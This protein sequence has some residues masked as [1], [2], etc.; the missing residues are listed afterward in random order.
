MNDE[1]NIKNVLKNILKIRFQQS[2]NIPLCR[3]IYKYYVEY[4]NA[5]LG[6]I[7]KRIFYIYMKYSKQRK[8]KVL[9]QWKIITVKTN[10]LMNRV[11]ELVHPQKRMW[12]CNSYIDKTS[13]HLSIETQ[14]TTESNII[15][16]K[17][18]DFS[19]IP[20][21]KHQ[22]NKY[23]I[24]TL[25]FLNR[26]YDK[27]Y[28]NNQINRHDE[29]QLKKDLQPN[30]ERRSKTRK[31][32]S[33]ISNKNS[34]YINTLYKTYVN[35]DNKIEQLRLKRDTE[36]SSIYPFT[37]HLSSKNIT[38]SMTDLTFP[39][40][41]RLQQYEKNRQ[42]HLDLLRNKYEL[43]RPHPRSLSKKNS[44]VII[45]ISSNYFEL[46]KRRISAIQT[47]M[48]IEHSL[49]FKPKLNDRRNRSVK[50]NVIIRNQHFI[51]ERENKLFMTSQRGEKECTFTPSLI[52]KRAKI[53]KSFNER[54]VEYNHLYESHIE[55]IRLRAETNYSFTPVL[56]SNTD[57][58][59]KNKRI[60]NE[61]LKRKDNQLKITVSNQTKPHL[62]VIEEVNTNHIKRKSPIEN[63]DDII[64][65]TITN[66][67]TETNE[68]EDVKITESVNPIYVNKTI[69]K[70]SKSSILLKNI[71]N[72]DSKPKNQKKKFIVKKTQKKKVMV[73]S[74]QYYNTLA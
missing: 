23:K 32:S 53:H 36:L 34:D 74:F 50:D 15:I 17:Q 2:D 52:S 65:E 35:R 64:K 56:S 8:R 9:Y 5:N 29:R 22:K 72:K 68:K 30:S 40:L 60:L 39:F 44:Q 55:A 25:N 26:N 58:I 62:N 45:P 27:K 66:E 43:E 49:T 4:D 7:I 14:P 31:N 1:T 48:D 16:T 61:Q 28:N 33:K 57:M 13:Y 41:S 10:T 47:E 6:G 69:N 42:S 20:K 24:L 67:R 11:R 3:N 51:T 21:K 54:L 18:N 37:P 38:S 73:N 70:S 63:Q 12:K 59:L 19:I 71:D 46:K